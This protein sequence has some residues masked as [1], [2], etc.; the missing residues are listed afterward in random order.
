MEKAPE[1]SLMFV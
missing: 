1:K